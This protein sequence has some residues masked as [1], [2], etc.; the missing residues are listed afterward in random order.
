MNILEQYDYYWQPEPNSG[1]YLWLGYVRGGHGSFRPC[2]QHK[3]KP[4]HVAR[5]VCEEYHG[6]PPTDKH[7]AA[8]KP[9]CNNHF[10]ISPYHLY[11]A[12]PSQNVIDMVRMC[13]EAAD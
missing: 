10:C 12:T 6:P 11:W 2:I 4:T 13:N 3:G 1:C 5:L 9:P 7:Q 8:H